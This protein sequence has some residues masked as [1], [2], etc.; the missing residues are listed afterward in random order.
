LIDLNERRDPTKAMR[1]L[2]GRHLR[3]VVVLPFFCVGEPRPISSKAQETPRFF[4]IPLKPRL[5]GSLGRPF[6][7]IV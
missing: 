1:R 7:E 5:P 2:V 4:G 6:P 3:G